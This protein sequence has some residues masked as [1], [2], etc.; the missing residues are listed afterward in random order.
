MAQ[1]IKVYDENGRYCIDPNVCPIFVELGHIIV[2]DLNGNITICKQFEANKNN[3]VLECDLKTG[4]VTTFYN[5]MPL[6]IYVHKY[7]IIMAPSYNSIEDCFKSWNEEDPE[8][9]SGCGTATDLLSLDKQILI[10]F[11]KKT[12]D[13]ANLAESKYEDSL[14]TL[15]EKLHK[16]WQSCFGQFY[17]DIN[18]DELDNLTKEELVYF[19]LECEHYNMP[20][21]TFSMYDLDIHGILKHKY[22]K[23]CGCHQNFECECK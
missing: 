9:P 20:Q 12:I 11:L 22:L 10:D 14:Y 2:H 16:A 17:N 5:K 23:P 3:D 19:I 8:E 7:G 18:V 21:F 1:F 4:K 13:Y 15:K 6:F